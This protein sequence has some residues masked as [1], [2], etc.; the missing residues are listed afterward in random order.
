MDPDFTLEDWIEFWTPLSPGQR[1]AGD[2]NP[3]GSEL[4]I[5][6]VY[7]LSDARLDGWMAFEELSEGLLSL[8]QKFKLFFF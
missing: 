6:Q 3:S 4:F 1:S 7:F 5:E 8:T 2:M